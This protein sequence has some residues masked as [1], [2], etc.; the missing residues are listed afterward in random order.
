MVTP[1]N[2]YCNE[3]RFSKKQEGESVLKMIESGLW[4]RLL[5]RG[6]QSP[7]ARR[8]ID[9]TASESGA[10]LVEMAICSAVLMTAIFGIIQFSI[11]LYVY[12][13]VA[14]AA[15]EA[16]RYAVVRGANSCLYSSTFPNCNLN[17]T[18]SGDPVGNYVRGLGF[19][20]SSGLS[21]AVTW[22]APSQ[23]ASGVTS[24]TTPCTGAV[25]SI[26][27]PCNTVGYAVRVVV[28]YSYPLSIPFVPSNTLNIHGTSQMLI[29][30]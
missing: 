14:E 25:D 30:E 10:T 16:T 29:N 21:A 27:N 4:F 11:A 7:T 22:W 9:A 26:G 5:Q 24:W 2:L 1:N 18:T 17:P 3:R 6:L 8:R 13:F 23:D 15:R 28:T 12:N 19:P 20:F